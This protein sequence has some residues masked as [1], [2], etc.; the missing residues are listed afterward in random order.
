MR[1][2]AGGPVHGGYTIA[3]VDG[4]VIL[5]EGAAPGE[6]VEVEIDESEKLWK[7]IVTE[8]IEPSPDRVPHVWDTAGGAELGYLRR[9]AQLA[10][11]TAV[12]EDAIGHLGGPLQGHLKDAGLNVRVRE[13]GPGLGTRTRLDVDV[14]E[15]GR[16]AMHARGSDALVAIDHMPLAA[17]AINDI[18]GSQDD[19]AGTWR[20]GDR[21]RLVAPT[22]QG[23]VVSV[24]KDVYKAPGRKIGARV[25]ERAAGYSWEVTATG[26]WQTHEKAPVTL[27]DAVLKGVRL[28]KSDRVAEF[29]GG[30]GLFTLPLTDQ[31]RAVRMWEGTAASVRDAERNAPKAEITR[32]SI[33]PSLLASGSEGADV[34]IADPSRAGLGIKGA[35]ALA[36]S[37]AQAIALVSCDPAAMARDVRAMI[38]NGRSVMSLAAFDLFPHTIHMEVVTILS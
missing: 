6:T 27:L 38:E 21:V 12:L 16:L 24:G 13:V 4:R 10:W 14:D 18:L 1:L 30:S 28:R 22:G 26:F 31:A 7:G 20:P 19:W 37:N 33:T 29:Y 11:K 8:V 25:V 34:V 3:R 17:P 15:E 36:Q 2:Q 5:V 32:A 9:S 23:P 35:T